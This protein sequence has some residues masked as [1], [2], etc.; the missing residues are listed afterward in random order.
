MQISKWILGLAILLA[1]AFPAAAQSAHAD[2][3]NASGQKIG[4]AKFKQT[5]TGVKISL[6]VS[7]TLARHARHPHPRGRQV[8]RP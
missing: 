5:S 2:I 4:E 8:R 3:Q 6:E 7:Q 1:A